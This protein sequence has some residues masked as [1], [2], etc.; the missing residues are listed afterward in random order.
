MTHESSYPYTATDQT[1][2]SVSKPVK[3]VGYFFVNGEA[4]V[5]DHLYNFGPVTMSFL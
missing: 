1:C 2:R 5:P 3:G 4:W